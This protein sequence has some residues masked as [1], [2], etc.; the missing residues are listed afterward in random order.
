MATLAFNNS[1][2]KNT[3]EW[4]DFCYEDMDATCLK[5]SRFLY[6]KYISKFDKALFDSRAFNLS[7]EEVNNCLIWRQQDATR[8]SIQALSQSLYS[9]KE[10]ERINT[11]KLQDKMFTEKGVNWN[12]LSTTKKRGSCCIKTIIQNSSNNVKED[13]CLREKW[14]IDNNIPIFSQ[15]TDY[16]NK[17]II[18]NT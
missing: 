16:V 6:E 5:Q 9:H 7:I 10:L 2:R 11:K 15:E 12:D 4:N 1:F 3:K 14:I 18:F 13:S 17:R 8:N